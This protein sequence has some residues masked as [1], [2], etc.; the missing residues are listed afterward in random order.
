MPCNSPRN[1]DMSA[2]RSF[3]TVAELGGVGLLTDALRLHKDDAE[4]QR[5]GYKA[6]RSLTLE[7]ANKR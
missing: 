4:M 3:V 2:L 5:W 7:R 6:L 1:L